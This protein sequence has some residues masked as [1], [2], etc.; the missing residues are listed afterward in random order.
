[1]SDKKN[2]EQ[3]VKEVHE[4]AKANG[5]AMAMLLLNI[6]NEI[7]LDEDNAEKTFEDNDANECFVHDEILHFNEILE[8]K[9]KTLEERI[10]KLEGYES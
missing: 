7:Y 5:N 4:L 1:M 2:Y 3:V 6:I 8:D 9:I 10:K